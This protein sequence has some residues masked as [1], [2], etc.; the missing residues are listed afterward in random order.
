MTA[1][2]L[3]IN[4][5]RFR[6]VPGFIASRYDISQVY[7]D[8]LY[9]AFVWEAEPRFHYSQV[10]ERGY[11]SGFAFGYVKSVH[12]DALMTIAY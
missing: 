8:I 9:S 12:F 11:C 1:S 10:W 3:C 2:V 4:Y 5:F 6:S 7:I